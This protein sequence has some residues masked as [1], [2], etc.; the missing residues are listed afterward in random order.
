MTYLEKLYF[1][2]F[3]EGVRYFSQSKDDENNTLRN[4]L[5]GTTVAGA[6]TIYGINRYKKKKEENQKI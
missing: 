6:G 4:A 2:G 5:I 1:I 3:N